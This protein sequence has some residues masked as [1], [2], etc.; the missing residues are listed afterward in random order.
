MQKLEATKKSSGCGGMIFGLI[1]VAVGLF[2]M[3]IIWATGDEEAS[4][5]IAFGGVFAVV[6]ALVVLGGVWQWMGKLKVAEPEIFVSNVRPRIGEQ[7]KVV[8]QQHFKGAVEVK[9]ISI[10][11]I[12]R[13][14]A[15][16]TQGTDTVTVHHD[17][18]VARL[19]YPPSR[20][21]AG[22]IIQDEHVLT[23][24]LGGMH[25]F[26]V[27]NNK[28]RWLLTVKVDVVGWADLNYEFEL[29]VMPEKVE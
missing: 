25:T 13:E 15:T 4:C 9:D 29:K 7:V 17:V 1:F 12:F 8:Y 10:Q 28:L 24:P 6:G 5:G 21:P 18:V 3:G 27:K 20:Y 19:N 26:I 14:S 11:L 16:Y 23:I 22:H 2:T